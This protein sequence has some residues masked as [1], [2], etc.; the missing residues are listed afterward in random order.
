LHRLAIQS[1]QTDHNRCNVGLKWIKE[2]ETIFPRDQGRVFAESAGRKP[3][4]RVEAEST[5]GLARGR[6][7]KF[8]ET[9]VE[10]S[11]VGQRFNPETQAKELVIKGD[12]KF[13]NPK[14]TSRP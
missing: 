8:V 10:K 11:R 7:R 4:S 2:S 5:Y 14:F 1:G 12:V 13:Q 6:G 3:L 9:D